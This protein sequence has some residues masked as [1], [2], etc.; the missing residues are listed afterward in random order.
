MAGVQKC[1]AAARDDQ[2]AGNLEAEALGAWCK[3]LGVGGDQQQE[4]EAVEEQPAE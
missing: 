1:R 2:D 3:A 4:L